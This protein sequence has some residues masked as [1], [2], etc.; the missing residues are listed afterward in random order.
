MKR[1]LIL[2]IVAILALTLCFSLASC[3]DEQEENP[4]VKITS[5]EVVGGSYTSSYF[6]GSTPDFSGIKLKVNYSD[7]QSKSVNATDAKVGTVDTSSAGAKVLTITYKG[8]S[9]NVTINVVE[10]TVTGIKILANTVNSTAKVGSVYS[11]D[12]MVVEASY[13]NGTK[14]AV[15]NEALTV[16][17]PDTA[18]AGTKLLKVTYLGFEAT[19]EVTV[20]KTNVTAMTVYG[21]FD[22]EIKVGAALDTSSLNVEVS[23][24]N[25]T[26]EIIGANRLTIVSIDTSSIGT[27]ELKITYDGFTI[28]YPINVYGAISLELNTT[29]IDTQIIIGDAFDTSEITATVIYSDKNGTT[30]SLDIDDLTI[31][32]NINTSVPGEQK[33][34]VSYENVSDEITVKVI[35]I[36]SVTVNGVNSEVLMGG[37]LDVSNITLTVKYAAQGVNPRTFT[38]TSV[39]AFDTT[40]PGAKKLTISYAL[41]TVEYDVK[42]CGPV[43]ISVEDIPRFFVGQKPSLDDMKV[44]LVY[45]DSAKTEIEITEYTT[46]LDSLDFNVDEDKD[47]VISAVAAGKTL[48]K[49]VKL[50]NKPLVAESLEITSYD[51]LLKIN[52]DYNMAGIVAK[53]TYTT[54][55]SKNLTVDELNIVS[56]I[57]KATAGEQTLKVSYTDENSNTVYAEVTVKVLPVASIEALNLPALKVNVGT[58]VSFDGITIEV[59]YS[60]G[61][62]TLTEN[63]NKADAEGLEISAFDKNVIGD[64][65]ITISYLG[66]SCEYT[67]HFKGIVAI[68]IVS[69]TYKDHIREGYE[70][71]ISNVEIKA[72]YSDGTFDSGKPEKFSA[73]IST[74]KNPE[75]NAV[76]IKVTLGDLTPATVE[77]TKIVTVAG[78]DALNGTVPSVLFKGDNLPLD[79]IALTV[80]YDVD[81]VLVPYLVKIG[82]ANLD[83]SGSG[84]DFDKENGTWA[85]TGDKMLT[86]TFGGS[87]SAVA[88]I[89][90]IAVESITLVDGTV[91]TTTIVGEEDKIDVQNAQFRVDFTDGSYTYIKYGAD[92]LV[93]NWDNY[94]TATKGDTTVSVTYKGETATITV[95]VIN[96]QTEG[97]LIFGAESPISITARESYKTS[98]KDS[99]NVYVVGDDNAFKFVLVINAL[100]ANDNPVS[101]MTYIGTSTVYILNKDTLEVSGTAGEEYVTIDDVKHTFDFTDAAIGKY[102]KIVSAPAELPGYQK[103]LIVEVVD[104][105]N[106]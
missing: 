34:K 104:G 11:V 41:G 89:S 22:S 66:K 68:E 75:T 2:F 32:N 96:R 16:T 86:L 67:L 102:F 103:E 94:S 99:N 52:H 105:Y 54:G 40:A 42:V 73:Q 93:W 3:G 79:K 87:Y 58:D 92:G 20:T 91:T 97:A 45:D 14:R 15:D 98:F 84:N 36:E 65:K 49:T 82:D 39:S 81:G 61:T 80:Y 17:L 19:L 9:V 90:V 23:F 27:K 18:T 10:P 21:D 63:V 72:T 59:T 88:R 43:E 70:L 37:T 13:N 83:Y 56:Q 24:D 95:S 76:T 69:G 48:T 62:D 30:K 47:L 78:V 44:Y 31:V 35:G 1:K 25:G 7:G 71:D 100:D 50:S 101:N 6:V 38:P 33:F 64:K 57:N 106:I 77:V 74:T 28:N 4:E 26:K 29:N 5:V 8:F 51:K 85:S 53:V 55:A 46:N 12:G 60:D